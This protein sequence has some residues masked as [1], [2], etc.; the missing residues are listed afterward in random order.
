VLDPTLVV[1]DRVIVPAL[2]VHD[3]ARARTM[4]FPL[5]TP[6]PVSAR[7]EAARGLLEEA[8]QLGIG[9]L[10]ASYGERLTRAGR[11]LEEVALYGLGRRLGALAALI[12]ARR[13][14]ELNAVAPAFFDAAVRLA[15]LD[16]VLDRRARSRGPEDS[17]TAR[18]LP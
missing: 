2:E 15:V 1:A 18:A 6:D 13:A 16:E 12:A 11:A 5:S 17:A 4:S 14:G 3:G 8:M 10:P 7:I 9:G